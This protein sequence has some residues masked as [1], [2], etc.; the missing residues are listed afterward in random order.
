[1]T[2]IRRKKPRYAE[3]G[4][5]LQASIEGGEYAV[6]S[7]L[8]TELELCERFSVSRHTARAALAQLV[9]VGAIKSW[10]IDA[11]TDLVE[12]VNVPSQTQLKHLTKAK[13]VKK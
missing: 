5:L 6:G 8:P 4:D 10:S 7:L 11:K 2:A 9:A 3:L 12:V 1:M 13:K